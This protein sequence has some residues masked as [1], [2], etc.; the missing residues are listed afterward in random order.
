MQVPK[1]NKGSSASTPLESKVSTSRPK[2]T[3]N[4]YM[5]PDPETIVMKRKGKGQQKINENDNV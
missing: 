5:I 2:G 3:L 4:L 1:S